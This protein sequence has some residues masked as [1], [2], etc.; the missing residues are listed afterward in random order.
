MLAMNQSVCC[1]SFFLKYMYVYVMGTSYWNI[2]VK[3]ARTAFV[4]FNTKTPSDCFEERRIVNTF[5]FGLHFLA[6]PRPYCLLRVS[7]CFDVVG[8]R[9][10]IFFSA[11]ILFA[12]SYFRSFYTRIL[13]EGSYALM[14]KRIRF[15]SSYSVWSLNGFLLPSKLVLFWSER[16]CCHGRRHTVIRS[17]GSVCNVLSYDNIR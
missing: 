3:I 11:M 9:N 8:Q 16:H 12:C 10:L 7:I 5:I 17:H 2:S 14:T 6:N 4:L 15:G 13:W 1:V